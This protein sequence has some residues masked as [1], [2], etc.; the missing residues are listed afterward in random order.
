MYKSWN[1]SVS[2]MFCLTEV[3]VEMEQVYAIAEVVRVLHKYKLIYN[4][5]T[6]T[7]YLIFKR[8]S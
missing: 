6:K 7:T 2:D 8:I 4:E 3:M 1:E 5:C